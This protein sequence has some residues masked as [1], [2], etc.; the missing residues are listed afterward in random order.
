MTDQ[1][2]EQRSYLRFPPDEWE[3]GLIQC[4]DAM[5]DEDNFKPEIAGLVMEESRAGCGL[6]VLDRQLT[7]RIK[8]RDR[9]LVKVARLG[10]VLAEVRW[11]K[12]LDQG[13]SRMGLNYLE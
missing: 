4:T 9:C 7:D 1:H 8:E 2:N 13:V 6:V 10:I 11:I 5:V 12:P 3:V